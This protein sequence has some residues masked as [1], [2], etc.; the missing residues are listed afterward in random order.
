MKQSFVLPFSRREFLKQSFCGFGSLALLSLLSDEHA[1][2]APVDPLAARPAHLP[3]PAAK[4]VI[5]LY[6][7]GGPSHLD[8]FDPKPLLNRLD[9]QPRPREFGEG[10]YQFVRPDARLLGSNR[11][12]TRHGQS[13]IDISDLFPH[14]ARHADD[15]AVLRACH[16]DMV[17]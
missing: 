16:G 1:Q 17:V 4:S 10:R 2:S 8:T 15:L 9:G 6:M 5:F 7:A 14:L 12:F 13:G 11:K 3:N